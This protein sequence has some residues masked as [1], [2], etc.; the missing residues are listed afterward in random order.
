MWFFFSCDNY[1]LLSFNPIY[2]LVDIPFCSHLLSL[3]VIQ[4]DTANSHWTFIND[5]CRTRR[6]K[7]V[8]TASREKPFDVVAASRKMSHHNLHINFHMHLIDL[9]RSGSYSLCDAN[10][11]IINL[12]SRKEWW[13]LMGLFKNRIKKK[14]LV[15]LD[16]VNYQWFCSFFETAMKSSVLNM[17][18]QKTSKFHPKK[19]ID[20]ETM[21]NTL[22]INDIECYV[23]WASITW[24]PNGT[25]LVRRNLRA[26]EKQLMAVDKWSSI[27][28]RWSKTVKLFLILAQSPQK[29]YRLM[30]LFVPKKFVD[31][32]IQHLHH[33]LDIVN[34]LL[35]E[36]NTTIHKIA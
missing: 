17:K 15:W 29:R 11:M 33:R 4:V 12:S 24:A 6:N 32:N 7:W 5:D 22:S 21:A 2:W 23:I 36:T 31:V 28:V 25:W 13:K 10:E 3:L 16:I 1:Y 8:D 27:S 20:F 14:H 18:R 34:R 35:Y 9:N 19:R 30:F 26:T